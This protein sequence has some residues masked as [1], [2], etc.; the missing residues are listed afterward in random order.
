MHHRF[1][2]SSVVASRRMVAP[3]NIIRSSPNH[4]YLFICSCSSVSISA[5]SR[6]V[7]GLCSSV[8]ILVVPR[9]PLTRCFHAS[10]GNAALCCVCGFLRTPR[11]PR[12]RGFVWSLRTWPP[13]SSTSELL[14]TFLSSRGVS[15]S[16]PR[17]GDGTPL[18]TQIIPFVCRPCHWEPF[19]GIN[20]VQYTI[21][22]W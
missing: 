3:I 18:R 6:S 11:Y 15:P 13:L 2:A 4:R 16:R 19:L 10:S 8:S 1:I 9:S 7:A 12:I 21:P 17:C 22:L 5:F 20:T 14:P